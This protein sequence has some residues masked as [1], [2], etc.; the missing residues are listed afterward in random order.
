MAQEIPISPGIAKA[1]VVSVTKM[2]LYVRA[3]VQ[4]FKGH[5]PRRR[6]VP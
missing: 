3:V 1:L 5:D 4:V 2:V 6:I